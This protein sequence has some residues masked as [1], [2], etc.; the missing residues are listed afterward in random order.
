MTRATTAREVGARDLLGHGEATL[1]RALIAEP[2]V[3]DDG[4]VEWAPEHRHGGVER[5]RS[6]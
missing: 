4:D 5:R 6:P 3:R 1:G 2:A